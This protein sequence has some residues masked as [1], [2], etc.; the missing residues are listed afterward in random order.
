AGADV[1]E[2]DMEHYG[3]L[4]VTSEQ[5]VRQ[6]FGESALVIR[7][8]L[9]V[10]PGDPSGRFAYWPHHLA[11]ADEV[12]VPGSP[13]DAVQLIDVRDLARWLVD[14]VERGV[15]GTMDANSAPTTRRQML[16]AVASGV[17]RKPTLT[18]VD[19]RFLAEHR[20]EPWM[21]QRSLPLWLPLPEYAGLM[22]RDVSAARAAGLATRPI[23]D[24]ARDTLAWLQRT[25]HATVT[26]LTVEEERDL[27]HRWHA[28]QPKPRT[29]AH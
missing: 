11:A 17:G 22:S 13:E 20:V 10:G 25:P 28:R 6:R 3:E 16:D 26:G 18:W 14:A 5:I 1:D 12:L 29:D 2:T 8:G 23:E 19:Q 15:R 24:T 4:K 7:P 27:L 9:I 21:G